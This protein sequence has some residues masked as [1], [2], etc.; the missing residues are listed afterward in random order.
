MNKI[1][2]KFIAY[3]LLICELFQ[4]TGVY[5]LTKEESVYVKLNE[6]GEVTS[7]S[8]TEHL[9][10][11]NGNTINDKT[12]LNNIKNING[13][14]KY[15]QKGNDLIWETNGS[16][17]YYQGSY[18]KDLPVSLSVKY[19]LDGKE[20]NVNEML[21]K[22]GN[23]K[24]SLTYKN[25]AYKMMNINGQNEKIFVPYGIV[26]STIIN[27]T[28]NKNIKVTNGKII[29]NGIGSVVMAVSLPGLYE[30]LKASD[31]KDLSNVEITY[32]T[33]SFELSSIYSV[34]TTNLFDD[35]NLN[36]LNVINDI[37]SS[38]QVLENSKI[39]DLLEKYQHY[40]NQDKNALKEQLLKIVEKNINN[41]TPVLSE[42]IAKETSI[43]I[44]EN[45]DEL[46]NDLIFYT[47]K[48]TKEV[49][50][51][52]VK[53]VIN[54]LDINDL[55]GKVI[56]T[57]LHDLLIN[58]S[59][60]NELSNLL[61]ESINEKLNTIINEEFNKI[62]DCINDNG[63]QSEYEKYV[64]DIAQK[65]GV[66]Y[67]QALGIV[68]DVRTDTLNQV[69][70]NIS[71]ANIPNTIINSLND[72]DYISNLVDN[73]INE[74]NTKLKEILS[75]DSEILDYSDELKEKIISKINNDFE[76]NN[77]SLN[78]DLK[79]YIS[80]T[81]DK[82]IDNTARDL[83]NKYTEKYTN[84]VVKNTIEKEFSEE[85]IDSNLRELLDIY[86]D[87]I[88]QKVTTLDNTIN[89]L[90]N[91]FN[92]FNVVLGDV[93]S[94]KGKFDALMKL[95]DEYKTV[96]T[97]PVDAN[98]NS[99]IIFMIDSISKPN[100][101]ESNNYKEKAKVSIWDKIKGLFK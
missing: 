91:S 81:T 59:E 11:Y 94:F 82:I 85:N 100:D 23:I 18:S 61:K 44:K 10:N 84:E 67:E 27:N 42:E 43:V 62:N 95:S 13:N 74:L 78:I 8:I 12:I 7:T 92:K 20:K 19:Y 28:D 22:K 71:E 40:R 14:E 90:S 32:D 83:A 53:R 37:N 35:I 9:F 66:T 21:G 46:E 54:E 73:Y 68:G 89:T 25:N 24:I 1:F 77:I 39:T 26:T 51:E 52:E 3:I 80:K 16:D 6:K 34:A 38:V 5:A 64:N 48:N 69:K 29:D 57:N 75:N 15:N 45:E 36:S 33:D 70:N 86:E 60:V 76:D 72:K 97:S 58:D 30:T 41:I 55:M 4:V 88:N 49:I 31:L 2:K 99:K 63:S 47:K 65:Y 87:D 98:S 17:I 56:N 96:D 93:N 50:D 101:I 79:E